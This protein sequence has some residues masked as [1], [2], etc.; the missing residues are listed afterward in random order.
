MSKYVH[1]AKRENNNKRGFLIVNPYLGKHVA[2]SPTEVFKTFDAVADL[3]PTDFNPKK[4]LVIG[5]A[6]T[7]T[8]LSLHYAIRNFTYFIQ[9]TRENVPNIKNKLYFS[10]SHSH[11]TEQYIITDNID[12]II[13]EI[14]RIIFIDDEIS[15]GNT[16]LHAIDSINAY[17]CKQFK[18][19]VVSILNGMN[20]EQKEI[21]T[22]RNIGVYALEYIDKSNYE[23]AVKDIVPNG[24]YQHVVPMKTEYETYQTKHQLDDTRCLVHSSSY[25]KQCIHLNHELMK[26]FDIHHNKI[27]HDDILILGNEE[28]MYEGLLFGKQLEDMLHA[29]VKF[30]A[31]TRSPIDVNTNSTYPLHERYELIS[32]YDNNRTT[33]LYDIKKYNCVIVMVESKYLNQNGL[34]TLLCALNQKNIHVVFI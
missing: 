14:E 11:A 26:H 20:N 6:E 24:K 7:A 23:D 25:S 30:H 4:T 3:I 12:K 31:T 33:Y 17:Y 18:Y 22:K 16:V 10:E 13:N 28:F 19:E 9:T 8:A 15:T 5:F 21:Y 34:D 27:I 32:C 29:N 1:L 2:I